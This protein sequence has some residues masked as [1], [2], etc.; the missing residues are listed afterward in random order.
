MPGAEVEDHR[1]YEERSVVQQQEVAGHED[2]ER[3]RQHIDRHPAPQPAPHDRIVGGAEVK[4][5]QE[6]VGHAQ[7]AIAEPEEHESHHHQEHAASRRDDPEVRAFGEKPGV[8]RERGPL[9]CSEQGPSCAGNRG[10]RQY[11]SLTK[12]KVVPCTM[13]ALAPTNETLT[14]LTWRSPARPDACSAPSMM[15]Q[16]PWMRP[17]LRLPPNVFSGSSPSSSMRPSWMKS[18]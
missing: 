9:R 4:L 5:A 3:Y 2:G 16:R 10:G 7:L 18:S 11:G 14:S 8:R 6:Q 15:C 17:V 13:G 1:R 12:M